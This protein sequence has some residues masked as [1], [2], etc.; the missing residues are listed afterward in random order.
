MDAGSLQPYLSAMNSWHADLGLAKLAVGH[1]I[2]RLHQGYGEMQPDFEDGETVVGRRPIPADTVISILQLARA[3][4]TSHSLH[5]AATANVICFVF[6]LCAD[7]CVRLRRKHVSFT[8]KGIVIQVLTKTRGRDVSTTVHRPGQD[9]WLLL[10]WTQFNPGTRDSLLWALDGASDGAFEST[11][12][13]WWL[14]AC[15]DALILHGE[16]GRSFAPQRRHGG[17]LHRCVL[18]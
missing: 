4:T 14:R 6:M 12:I 15:C 1:S 10:E 9:V 17:A 7:S 11:C 16:V 18:A 3:L 8:E 5:R 13:V 2:T